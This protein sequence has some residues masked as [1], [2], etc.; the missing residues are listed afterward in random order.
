MI[1][2][3][4]NQTVR[5]YKIRF[6]CLGL[7]VLAFATCLFWQTK[8]YRAVFFVVFCVFTVGFWYLVNRLRGF[9]LQI[10]ESAVII[11]YG[12]LIK[13]QKIL[14]F[15]CISHITLWQ[16][17]LNKKAGVCGVVLKSAPNSTF[18]PEILLSSAIEIQKAVER[19]GKGGL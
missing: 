15:S 12:V 18:I 13:A 17:P 11:K 19:R 1:F 16:T 2:S 5:I 10:S 6:L 3:V 9:T 14:P 4:P 8:T 7:T